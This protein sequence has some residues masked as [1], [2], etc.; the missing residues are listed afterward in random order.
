MAEP[1]P[2]EGDSKEAGPSSETTEP[3]DTNKEKRVKLFRKRDKRVKRLEKKLELYQRK[4]R[5][6]MEMEVT[7]E[8]MKSDTSPYLKEDFIK[9]KFVKVWHELC[10]VVG[11]SPEIQENTH[12]Y[13]SYESTPYPE[14]NRRVERLL[15]LDEFPDYWDVCQLVNRVN[16]KHSLG[17][18]EREIHLL[19]QKIFREVGD[20]IKQ[21]RRQTYSQLFGSHLTDLVEEDP[22]LK[23]PILLEQLTSSEEL[24]HKRLEELYDEFALRQEK[25]GDQTDSSSEERDRLKRQ[26][27]DDMENEEQTGTGLIKLYIFVDVLVISSYRSRNIR[28]W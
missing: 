12:H 11:I 9:R 16:E 23:D 10:D 24:G 28:H 3:I 22:A 15:K 27:C 8:E 26:K 2:V 25:E 6:T 5:Q 20:Q 18:K 17:I 19:S 21:Q 13:H 4:I 7:L 1:L 14:I